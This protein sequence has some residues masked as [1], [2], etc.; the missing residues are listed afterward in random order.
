MPPSGPQCL[1]TKSNKETE[2]NQILRVGLII[3]MLRSTLGVLLE[4]EEASQTGGEGLKIAWQ[5]LTT[6][7]M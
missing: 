6:F 5:S 2:R 7:T 1:V 4:A 3:E